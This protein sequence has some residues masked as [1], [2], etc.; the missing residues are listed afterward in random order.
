MSEN[1]CL[2]SRFIIHLQNYCLLNAFIFHN[3]Y[4]VPSSWIII[5]GKTY[6]QIN[7]IQNMKWKTTQQIRAPLARLIENVN[8]PWDILFFNWP[9]DWNICAFSLYVIIKSWYIVLSKKVL[10]YRTNRRNRTLLM[11]ENQCL[12]SFHLNLSFSHTIENLHIS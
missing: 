6:H 2:L 8:T 11:L 9:W 3:H 10:L 5:N 1:R 12:S 4:V 7:I